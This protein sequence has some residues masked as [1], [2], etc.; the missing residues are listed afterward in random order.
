VVEYLHNPEQ[1]GA[2]TLFATHY[3]ELTELENLKPGIKNFSIRLKE[4]PD[5]VIFLRKIIPGPADQS[6]GIE[7]AKLA[8][9]P[10]GVTH[11]A[12]EILGHLESG[13]DTYRRELL[14]KEP[15]L[16]IGGKGDQLNFF[17]VA[18]AMTEEEEAVLAAIRE[19]KIDEMTPMEVMNTVYQLRKKL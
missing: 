18:K 13:E 15:P 8:G 12:Q 19:L 17:D 5:G 6:Y 10:A 3:H 11:R 2:K 14:V 4:T 7:V 9:F 16:L 1:I